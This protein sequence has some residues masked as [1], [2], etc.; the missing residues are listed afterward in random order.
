MSNQEIFKS[1]D[2]SNVNTVKVDYLAIDNE[3][4]KKFDDE[5]DPTQTP[6]GET[7]VIDRAITFCEYAPEVF[8]ALRQ[9]DGIDM[10]AVKKSLDPT[11]H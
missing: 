1:F 9:A 7:T 2:Y 11:D 10:E 3:I 6:S 4:Y 5:N 8:A